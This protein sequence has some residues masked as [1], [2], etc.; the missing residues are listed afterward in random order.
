VRLDQTCLEQLV[1]LR[2]VSL[3]AANPKY[4]LVRKAEKPKS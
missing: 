1:K 3:V 4:L 2:A